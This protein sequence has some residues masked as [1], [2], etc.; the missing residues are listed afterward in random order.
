ME[1]E[2][3]E[4]FREALETVRVGGQPLTFKAS[5]NG[6]FSLDFG[7]ANLHNQPDA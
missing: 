3:V 1:T 7:Q 2:Y 6:F 5:D 4:A